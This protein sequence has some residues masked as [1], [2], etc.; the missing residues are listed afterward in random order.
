MLNSDGNGEKMMAPA[1]ASGRWAGELRVGRSD[2]ADVGSLFLLAFPQAL[3][4]HQW[5]GGSCAE[6]A[7]LLAT[8]MG[9]RRPARPSGGF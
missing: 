5:D 2:G 6:A 3:T 8:Y 7:P 1:T 4:S 9:A